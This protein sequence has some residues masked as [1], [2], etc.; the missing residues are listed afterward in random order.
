MEKEGER[1]DVLV[2]GAGL[3]SLTAAALLAK[4]GLRVLCVEQ[5]AQPGGSCGAFRLQGRTIDQG[6]SMFFGFGPEGFNPHHY[7]M[8]VLEEPIDVI[9]HTSMY[10]LV[11]GGRPIDFHADVERY[12]SILGQLFGQAVDGIRRC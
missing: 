6:T 12:L 2:I 7:V 10:R 4:R 8:N 5:H 9:K 1:F 3:S 11:Y